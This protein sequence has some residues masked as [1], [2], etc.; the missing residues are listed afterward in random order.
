MSR[1]VKEKP[2]R[3]VDVA[4]RTRDY[5]SYGRNKDG[6]VNGPEAGIVREIY[7][8]ILAGDSTY[9][10]VENLNE[11]LVPTSRGNMWTLPGLTYILR[12]PRLAGLRVE[13]GKLVRVEGLEPIVTTDEYHQMCA[14]LDQRRSPA[15]P[16]RPRRTAKSDR[17][18]LLTGGKCV[19]GNCGTA[20]VAKRAESRNRGYSCVKASPHNGCGKIRI[21]AEPLEDAVAIKVLGRLA[22]PA[23]MRL[24]QAAVAT[25]DQ[26]GKALAA[27]IGEIQDEI[28]RLAE[29][30]MRG[31]LGATAFKA[32]E[33]EG[34]RQIRA[35]RAEIKVIEAVSALPAFATPDDLAGWW[36]DEA[37]PMQDR[38]VLVSA[39]IDEI[40]IG[41]ASLPGSHR[42]DPTRVTFVWRALK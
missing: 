10:W 16:S 40:R 8:G 35:L 12:N 14:V 27:S 4:N 22:K 31:E 30:K 15:R 28:R 13:G 26:T 20:M 6:S 38:H 17:L 19:C 24:L 11:R 2:A 42:F 18:Y 32:A 9:R 39:I 33:R 25:S 7:K 41:P 1:Q 37:T 21:A 5:R 23:N 34:E 36:K 3:P 29:E